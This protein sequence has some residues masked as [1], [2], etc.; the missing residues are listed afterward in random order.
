MKKFLALVLAFVL[1]P[2]AATAQTN[3]YAG[4]GSTR[5]PNYPQPTCTLTAASTACTVITSPP[6][7]SLLI[8]GVGTSLTTATFQVQGSLDGTNYLA[9]NIAPMT[10]AGA[11]GTNALSQTQTTALADYVVNTVGWKYIKVS[12]TSGTFTGTSLAFQMVITGQKGLQ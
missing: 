8:V 3:Y 1:T 12:T 5:F 9:L 7:V 11:L 6:G 10:A 4:Q 2:F